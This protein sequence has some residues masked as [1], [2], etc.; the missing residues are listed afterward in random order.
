MAFSKSRSSGRL[1][2]QSDIL[3]RISEYQ[4][5][6]YYLGGV[7]S[8]KINSPL[9]NDVKPSFSVFFS[10]KWDRYMYKDF[11]SGERGNA[12]V[13][14]M[15]LFGFTRIT[16]AF[17][18]IAS[19]FSLSGFEVDSGNSK[20]VSVSHSGERKRKKGLKTDIKV[21]IRSWKNIDRKYWNDLYGFEKEELEYCNIYPIS[22]YFLNGACV[23]ANKH[24]YVFVEEKDGLQ[25]FKIYQPF[26]DNGSKWFNNNDY[27][28]WELWSQLPVKGKILVITS[29]RKDAIIIK[30]LFPSSK[31]T[32]CS[33]QSENVNPKEQVILELKNRFEKIF[34]LYDNDFNNERNPGREA[35]K[36]ISDLFDLTQIE[37]PSEFKLKDPSDFREAHGA[38]NTRSMLLHLINNVNEKE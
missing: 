1:P 5:F 26:A 12:F 15:K 4:I 16:E 11:S 22:H 6:E 31:I 8:N 30:K 19:D 21:R 9:R 34:V 2:V 13:F 33:L 27:S 14:V 37:I 38:E 35:G 24:A 29:S 18:K 32:S 10:E 3:S 23:V 17:N 28:T 20:K 7:P 25:T 36:K